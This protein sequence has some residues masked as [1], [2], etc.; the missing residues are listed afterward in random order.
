MTNNTDRD[1]DFSLRCKECY[2][3]VENYLND[4][5][6]TPKKPGFKT[7]TALK[8][9]VKS[10]IKLTVSILEKSIDLHGLNEIAISYNGGKDCLVMLILLL[11]T[12]YKKHKEM[13][14]NLP[15]HYELDSIYINSETP[16]PKLIDFIHSSTKYYHLNQIIIK[17]TLKNGFKYYLEQVNT[18]VK[19]VIVGIRYSD[20]Y[21]SE[22][23]YEQM[24]DHN[25]PKFLR[26]HPILHWHYVDIWQFLI[27]TG[28]EYCEMY[29]L[30]YTSLGGINRTK[31]NPDL[32][33]EN[34]DYL[35]AYMLKDHA[36]E[37]ERLGRELKEST[38]IPIDNKID[39]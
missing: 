19:S 38:P 27:S 15:K 35:P 11:S 12:I 17:D 7:T 21:G 24:T 3:I 8:N 32:K 29:D 4:N 28:I 36:D 16:F 25:W 6:P 26:I 10:K 18:N 22:L 13:S 1:P 2:E 9:E 5:L 34:G 39:N 30:G 20:P 14:F 33:L 37:K 23:K 31:P